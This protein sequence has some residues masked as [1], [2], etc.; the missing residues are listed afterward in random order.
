M[1]I[2]TISLYILN[3]YPIILSAAHATAKIVFYNTGSL[4]LDSMGG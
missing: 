3:A 2:Q 4:H 1:T